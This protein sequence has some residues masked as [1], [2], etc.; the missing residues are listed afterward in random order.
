LDPDLAAGNYW[1]LVMDAPACPNDGNVAAQ[2]V[3][4][5]LVVHA[6][7]TAEIV[8]FSGALSYTEGCVV[9]LSSTGPGTL[10]IETDG[11]IVMGDVL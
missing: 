8:N 4:A 5:A 10:T 6:D 7:D 11:M 3:R 2:I 9:A 1:V